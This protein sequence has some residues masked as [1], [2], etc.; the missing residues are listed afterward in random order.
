MTNAEHFGTDLPGF[1]TR[2]APLYHLRALDLMWD[3]L[4]KGAPLTESQVLRTMA[5]GGDA[6]HAPPLQPANV[7]PIPLLPHTEDRIS[8]EKGRVAIPE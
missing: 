2:V 7:P 4:T 6:G 5:R 1:D 8:V 3:H